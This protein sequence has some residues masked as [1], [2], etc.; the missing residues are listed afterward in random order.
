MKSKQKSVELHN[1][2]EK[3]FVS[4]V[5]YIAQRQ[6]ERGLVDGALRVL[7]ALDS[8]LVTPENIHRVGVWLRLEESDITYV[9]DFVAWLIAGQFAVHG[10]V[11]PAFEFELD[12]RAVNRRLRVK[13]S[14]SFSVVLAVE[15]R[16]EVLS[17]FRDLDS[18]FSAPSVG[19][20]AAAPA[21]A[22]A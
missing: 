15:S 19:P 5:S 21:A 1:S 22:T 18:A 2:L 3:L 9:V 13:R 6:D 10:L 11:L 14:A 20:M 4:F 16:S 7:L 17:F 12:G 8:A